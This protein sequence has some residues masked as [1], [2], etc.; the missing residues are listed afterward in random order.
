M[1]SEKESG[2]K[3]KMSD[4]E[5]SELIKKLDKDLEEHFA[6]LE[7]KAAERGPQKRLEGA[8]SEDNWEEEMQQ[9][10][11]FSQEWKEGAELSPLMQGLQDLK[12]STEENTP[13][14]L[15][16][17]YKEDGNFNFKCKKYRFAIASYT[18]GLK[19]KCSDDL[20]NCQLLT[21][22][23]A[24]QFHISNFRS[25]LLDSKAALKINNTHMKAVLRAAQCC[26]KLK[27]FKDCIQLCDDGIKIE[28][29]NQELAKMRT[30]SAQ[31]LKQLERDSRKQALAEKKKV[32]EE[33][34]LL[35]VITARGIKVERKRGGGTLSLSDLEP[36]H[37]AALQNKV[38]LVEGKL[39]FPVLFLYPEVGETDFIEGFLEG[40][41]FL[42]HI[43]NMFGPQVDRPHWD[44]GSRYTPDKIVIYFETEDRGLQTIPLDWTLTQALTSKQ[45]ILKAGT[46]GFILFVNQSKAHLDF[47][48]KYSS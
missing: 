43:L 29:D 42:D 47:L 21:N 36:C 12:Y 14:E 35:D 41:S 6:R 48:Q 19:A 28:Q 24:A 23:A 11:F 2:K 27:L 40:D 39:V 22:R 15:A 13:A 31:L 20:L 9:H 25:S 46:P 3:P 7:A 1:S 26:M 34:E 44:E 32:K 5:R 33:N 10:P 18:E 45:F 30:E 17:N 16:A 4:G 8:W 38:R 37:P